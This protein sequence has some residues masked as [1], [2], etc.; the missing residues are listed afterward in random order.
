MNGKLTKKNLR[1]IAKAEETIKDG[2]LYEALHRVGDDT[3]KSEVEW[4]LKQVLDE[5]AY[6]KVVAVFKVAVAP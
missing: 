3:T 6:R 2:D 5:A 1:D 4:A